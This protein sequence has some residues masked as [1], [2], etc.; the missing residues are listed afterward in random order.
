VPVN[1]VAN[2]L[3]NMKNNMEKPN[4]FAF[5]AKIGES[6]EIQ[7]CMCIRENDKWMENDIFSIPEGHPELSPYIDEQLFNVVF[8]GYEKDDSKEGFWIT[9]QNSYFMKSDTILS[10][11]LFNKGEFFNTVEK[12][13]QHFYEQSIT[14]EWQGGQTQTGE[15]ENL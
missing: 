14:S 1:F 15:Q 4:A 9:H 13:Y 10:E 11:D 2:V 3:K 7:L 12:G 6:Q 8:I 5:K